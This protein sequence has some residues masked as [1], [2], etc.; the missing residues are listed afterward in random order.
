MV[1]VVTTGYAERDAAKW[2]NTFGTIAYS[3][4][5]IICLDIPRGHGRLLPRGTA[6]ASRPCVLFPSIG[7]IFLGL[8]VVLRTTNSSH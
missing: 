4:R 1:I 8:V 2:T 5:W 3:E 6:R 7:L